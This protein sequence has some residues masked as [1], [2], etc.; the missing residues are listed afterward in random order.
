MYTF[1]MLSSFNHK[2]ADLKCF[3]LEPPMSNEMLVWISYS[4]YG[5]CENGRCR[6]HFVF[7]YLQNA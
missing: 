3:L 2:F 5:S 6:E 7:K 1:S 4:M